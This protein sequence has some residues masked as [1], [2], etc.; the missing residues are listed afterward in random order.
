MSRAHHIRIPFLVQFYTD[1]VQGRE[2]RESA[3][4][5]AGMNSG[6]GV[7]GLSFNTDAYVRGHDVPI[8]PDL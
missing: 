1:K 8:C 5:V 4:A 3:L 6:L 7:R 2:M